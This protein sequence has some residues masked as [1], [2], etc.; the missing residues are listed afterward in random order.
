MSSVFDMDSKEAGSKLALIN[1]YLTIIL[2]IVF[3]TGIFYLYVGQNRLNDRLFDYMQNDNRNSLKVIQENKAAFETNTNMLS[4][5]KNLLI[6]NRTY[7]K[8]SK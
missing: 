7:F 8:Q 5:I 3:G 6:E 1:K 4:E 2:L